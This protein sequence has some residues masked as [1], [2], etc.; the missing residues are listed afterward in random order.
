[1]GHFPASVVSVRCFQ[2]RCQGLEVAQGLPLC[3]TRD[4]GAHHSK[5]LELDTQEIELS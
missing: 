2:R 1:M 5:R 4:Y 3:S